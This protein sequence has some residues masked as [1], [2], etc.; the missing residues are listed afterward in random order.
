MMATY[1]EWSKETWTIREWLRGGSVNTA[2]L[3]AEL[4]RWADEVEKWGSP[5][6]LINMQLIDGDADG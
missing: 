4:R 1:D 5:Q 2:N 6:N 3:A